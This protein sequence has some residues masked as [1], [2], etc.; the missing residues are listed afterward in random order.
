MSRTV[1]ILMATYNGEN[2][3]EEQIKSILNQT[4]KNF[5]LIIRDD[6]STDRTVEIIKKIM[7]NDKRIKLYQNEANLGYVK[8][9]EKL[10]QDSSSSLIAFSDQDD[11]WMKEKVE[12]LVSF[13]EKT[14]SILVFCD[15]KVTDANLNVINESFQ[16]FNG[17]KS[18]CLKYNDF[19]L[20]KLENVISGCSMMF[21]RSILSNA[22]PFP[23]KSVIHDWWLALLATQYGKVSFLNESL[24][25]YRQH[26]KNSIG[27]RKNKYK[28]FEDYRTKILNEKFYL[29]NLLYENRNSF[30]KNEADIFDGYNYFF[31]VLNRKNSFFNAIKV[32]KIYN[33]ETNS[34]KFKMFLLFNLPFIGKIMYNIKY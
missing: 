15:M 11:V 21:D 17:K 2:F 14:K 9:F 25:Y 16:K 4:Y 19:Y 18:K 32:F 31:K 30:K 24:Q 28:T 10:C 3:V 8:N 20:L 33:T 1:D 34:R 7:K 27:V 22:Y 12:K 5:N 26:D 23:C 6:C 13:M 29:Y